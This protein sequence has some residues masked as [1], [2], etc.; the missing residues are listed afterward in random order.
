MSLKTTLNPFKENALF[1]TA[2][3]HKSYSYEHKITTD[4]EKLEFLGDAV[5]DLVVGELLME[6][7]PEDSEGSL[8]KKRASL[9]NER[10]LFELAQCHGLDQQVK[11]GKGEMQNESFKNPRIIA[12]VY[13]AVIGAIFKEYGFDKCRRFLR[14]DFS[15]VMDQIKNQLDFEMDYKTRLQE[16]IQKKI[17]ETPEYILILE[18]GPSHQRIFEVE[19]RLQGEVLSQGIGKSKK[20]AEQSAAEKALKL[21]RW[22]V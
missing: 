22:K 21:E 8:S 18:E 1:K 17:K 2:L 12:S 19:V 13:E 5:I 11:L 20:A 14:T 15:Q 16:L 10:V 7:F 4:N 6:K 3:L 9:V